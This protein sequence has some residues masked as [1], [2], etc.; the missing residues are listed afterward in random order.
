MTFVKQVAMATVSLSALIGATGLTAGPA[1]AQS[2]QQSPAA[3]MKSE[4]KEADKDM[5]RV[6]QKLQALGAKPIG[7]QSVEETRKGPTPADA[8]KAV[9]K[10]EGKDPMALMAAMKIA[11][12]DMTYPTA[13]GTQPVRIYTPE[14]ASGPLPV[15]LY[16]HGG[17][18]VIADIDTYEASAMALAKKANAIVASVEYRHAP[19]NKFPAAHEDVNAAYRWVL[20]NAGSF[21]GDAGRI[22]L[23]GESAGGNMAVNVA[24][25]ARDQKLQMPV[26]VVAVYPVAGTNT[27]TPSYQKNAQAMPLSKAAME[28]FFNNT[29]SK[30]EDMQDPRFDL[31]GHADLKGLPPT[32]VI[33]D[34]IDPLMSEGKQLADKLKQAGVDTTYENFDG[35]AHEFFGMGLVVKDAERAEDLAA[36]ELKQAFAKGA[37][38]TTSDG[39]ANRPKQ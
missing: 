36:K 32:L 20:D 17:G 28:W 7:T 37:K 21:S 15:I 13:G 11:K 4:M 10:D 24:I 34:E 33:T 23:A 12:K 1:L 14:G 30:P 3:A 18:W 6:L 39:T 35:V 22:A 8:V 19:E 31:V 16:I 38:G 29:V 5:G 26:A 9:L 27:N 25:A 2:A